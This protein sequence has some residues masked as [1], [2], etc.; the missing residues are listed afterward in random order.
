[1]ATPLEKFRKRFGLSLGDLAVRINVSETQLKKWERRW[2]D[3]PPDILREIAVTY[4]VSVA[5]ILGEECPVERW[6]SYPFAI[7]E[8]EELYGTLRLTF[9]DGHQAEFP[10]S[11]KVRESVLSQLA[12]R[13]FHDCEN[14]PGTEPWLYFWTLD[15]RIAFARMSLLS[16]IDLISDDEREA[17]YHAHPEVY[18]HLLTFSYDDD[19][20]REEE[21]SVKGRMSEAL[22]EHYEELG[23]MSVA[24]QRATH[25]QLV[26]KDGRDLYASC[27][28]P[29]EVAGFFILDLTASEIPTSSFLQIEDSY[30]YH[31]A[32]FVNLDVLRFISIPSEAYHRYSAPEDEGDVAEADAGQA[33]VDRTT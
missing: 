12:R 22:A 20:D 18:R 13:S 32:Y 7:N 4:G 11:I 14:R 1:M 21:G 23:G 27:K 33:S 31:E 15:D 26:F 10:I 24:S 28:T 29:E 3:I 17:P 2:E 16:E 9:T 8:P 6:G 5:S 19:T 25:A 30:D